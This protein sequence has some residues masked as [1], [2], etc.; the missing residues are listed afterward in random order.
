MERVHPIAQAVWEHQNARPKPRALYRKTINSLRYVWF[1]LLR[2][3]NHLRLLG[4]TIWWE[5][6][7]FAVRIQYLCSRTLDQLRTP[8][9]PPW[10]PKSG[11]L[12]CMFRRAY[13]QSIVDLTANHS[14]SS[15]MDIPL[16]L[17]GWDKAMEFVSLLSPEDREEFCKLR[18][19]ANNLSSHE[20]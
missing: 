3:K 12:Q 16:L 7:N 9:I 13:N 5:L 18:K 15:L 17:N 1:L 6:C 2:R 19:L 14:A 20:V 11:Y 4:R 8:M 10:E